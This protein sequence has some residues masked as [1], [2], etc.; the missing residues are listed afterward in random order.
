MRRYG[1]SMAR[2]CGGG[3]ASGRTK[4][5]DCASEGR[6]HLTAADANASRTS[7]RDTKSTSLTLEPLQ[8]PLVI[9]QIRLE[10]LQTLAIVILH[11]LLLVLRKDTTLDHLG[12]D[13]Y[14]GKPLE[15]KPAAVVEFGFD[16]DSLH[17]EGRFDADTEFFW[18]I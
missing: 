16:L 13:G 12:L 7:E 6:G 3:A 14:P 4:E 18:E 10:K 1:W 11:P 9:P 17:G 2:K 8:R 15:A 5:D